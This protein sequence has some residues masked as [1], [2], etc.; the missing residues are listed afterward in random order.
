MSGITRR[1]LIT[2]VP[3]ATAA[4]VAFSR[5]GISTG[6]S[7]ETTSVVAETKYGKIKGARNNGVNI[8]KGVPYAGRVSGDRRFRKPA[9]LE[10]WAGVR[11]ALQLG[12]PAIQPPNQTY[13]INEPAPDE[14]CLVLNIWT[15]GNDNN[16]RPVMFYNHG[17][18][19]ATGS[20]GSVSQDGT[21]LARNFDVVV[22]Q[23]NHR[24]GI[25]GY[26]YL[27]EVA[28][29]EYEG[30]GNMGMLDIVA[31]LEWVNQNIAA[32]GGDP[33]N[34][35]VFGE[36]GGG[37][38]TSCIYAMPSAA[39]YFNKVS[40]ESGPGIRM[41][42]SATANQTTLAVLK[43]LN[44]EPKDWR[45]LLELPVADLLAARGGRFGPVVDGVVLPSHPFDTKAPEISKNKPLMVGWNET[46][47]TFMAMNSADKSMF[48][49]DMDGLK[50]RLKTQYGDNTQ[51]V[52]DAYQKNRPNAS[53]SDIF[54]AIQSMSFAGK[55]SLE[56]GE[57]KAA[58]NGAPAYVYNFGYRSEVKIPGTDYPLG[59]PH[60]ME[61][62][63]KFNNVVPT[64]SSR[65][66]SGMAGNRPERFEASKNMAELWSTFA[67]TGKPAAKG[68]PDWPAY[69]PPTRSIMRIDSKCEVI[70]DRYAPERQLWESL[71]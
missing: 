29:K 27:D 11:D 41:T 4:A 14:D 45:K 7:A 22:V 5:F 40:I 61:I 2:R 59:T 65:S 35:M 6:Y 48:S 69:V 19:F 67:R 9:P 30:S 3:F 23:T 57:K 52:I 32:F 16:K 43:A 53:P 17:G 71:G 12:H 60:A 28:G 47:Y 63:F 51:K 33:T 24:L 13:G 10:P 36:S 42:E 26:L 56:I 66:A 68:Q 21:N 31:G 39:P 54:V 62:A 1:Q 15:P 58:Q 70:N 55:G 64:E 49:L 25:M 37:S 38:K 46:E 8:F 20:G 50:T 34:V 18:G 44:I